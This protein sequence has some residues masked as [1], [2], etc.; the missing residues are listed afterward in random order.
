MVIIS[1]I[2]SL[3]FEGSSNPFRVQLTLLM[4]LLQKKIHIENVV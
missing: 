1:F 2:A 4:F 3:S